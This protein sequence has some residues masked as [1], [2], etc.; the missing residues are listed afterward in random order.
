MFSWLLRCVFRRAVDCAPARRL[1]LVRARRSRREPASPLLSFG[2]DAGAPLQFVDHGRINRRSE[3]IAVH[4]VSFRSMGQ[5]DRGLSALAAGKGAPSRGRLRPRVGWRPP[6]AARPRAGAGRPRR[7]RA[8][9]HGAVDVEPA[10]AKLGGGGDSEGAAGRAGAGR[11][12][13]P[14]CRRRAPCAAAGRPRAD[15]LSRLERRRE[16]GHVRRRVRSA[17]EGARSPLGRR[18]AGCRV[19]RQRSPERPSRRAAGPHAT[20]IRSATS[21]GH[22]RAASCSRTG[23]RTRPFRMPRW[24]TSSTPRRRERRCAGTTRRTSSMTPPTET[25]STG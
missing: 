19:R 25:P 22:A 13:R 16:G 3:P 12:R 1:R 24:R 5:R 9:D 20:S 23:E 7:R 17:R 6:R 14:A 15:R 2:Y 21:R 8:D 18:C 11:R 10:R 4:D